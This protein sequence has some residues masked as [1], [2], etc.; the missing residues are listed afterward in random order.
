MT[1]KEMNQVL[2]KQ[3]Y[4]SCVQIFN[5]RVK[6]QNKGESQQ[7]QLGYDIKTNTHKAHVRYSGEYYIVSCPFC[8][9]TRYRLYIN[10]RF[11]VS[12]EFGRTEIHL[13]H[14]FNEDCLADYRNR[15]KLHDLVKGH[16]TFEPI[17]K[18][19]KELVVSDFVTNWPGEVVRVDK[20]PLNHDARSYLL[21]RGFDPVRIGTYYNVHFCHLTD[22]WLCKNRL[23]IPIYQNKRMR[24]WQARYVGELDW[25]DP[26]TPPKYYTCPGTPR[27]QLLYNAGNASSYCT[28]IITEGVTD[29]WSVGPMSVC[30]L[31]ASMTDKQQSMFISSFKDH[32]GVLLYDPEEMEKD[33]TKRLISNMIGKFKN[34]FAAVTLPDGVD[35]GSLERDTLR[36]YI[37][38]KALEQKCVV[39]WKRKES[40]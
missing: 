16:F 3:L 25:K 6:I 1:T 21:S 32:A 39:S 14:C 11:G 17:V 9:D 13:A 19:G 8:N 10:H 28:G 7:R 37:V 35:P 20:L 4:L 22:R 15:E 30:T 33:A 26:N 27:S 24:G 36:S 23:I 31:G 38:E 18:K 12:D 29:V 40:E 5:G 2:N 34:G